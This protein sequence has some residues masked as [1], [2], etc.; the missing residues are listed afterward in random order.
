MYKLSENYSHFMQTKPLIKNKRSRDSERLLVL[1]EMLQNRHDHPD[2]QTC[3]HD[4]QKLVPGIGQSTVYRHLDKLVQNGLINEI[5]IDDGP[6]KFDA[7]VDVHAHFVCKKCDNLLDISPIN[8]VADFPG[9]VESAT[10]IAKGTCNNCS[11]NSTK[12]LKLETRKSN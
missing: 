10:Y 9:T 3:L 12:N 8:V 11:N 1:L 4:M 6:A 7:D 2:A 5:R